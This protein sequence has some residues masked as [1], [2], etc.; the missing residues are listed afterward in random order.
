MPVQTALDDMPAL[1]LTGPEATR[2]RNGQTVSLLRRSQ[3]GRIADL[4][5]G[6]VLCA[7]TVGRAVAITRYVAGEVRPLRVLNL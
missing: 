3:L 4:C 5:D 6:M 7:M 2:L 1:S